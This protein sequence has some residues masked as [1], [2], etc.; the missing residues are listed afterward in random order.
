MI[1]WAVI[2]VMASRRTRCL[3]AILTRAVRRAAVISNFMIARD[4]HDCAQWPGDWR[5]AYFPSFIGV[6]LQ[7]ANLGLWRGGGG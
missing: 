5:V 1:F 3:V 4:A 7:S 6:V 2:Y